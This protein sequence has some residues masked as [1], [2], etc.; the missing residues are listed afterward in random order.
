M[1]V[2]DDKKLHFVNGS[3]ADSALPFNSGVEI[4]TG[5][6]TTATAGGVRNVT[7][8][9]APDMIY[10]KF[11]TIGTALYA[12]GIPF[13]VLSGTGYQD[14]YFIHDLAGKNMSTQDFAISPP[15]INLTPITPYG[16]VYSGQVDYAFIY[17]NND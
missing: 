1:Y 6:V 13:G 14:N 2:G 8:E 17:F 9:K 15:T 11:G 16:S 4:V 12:P 5:S 7:V 3:G 10:L